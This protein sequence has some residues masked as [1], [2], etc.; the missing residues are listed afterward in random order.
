[1]SRFKALLSQQALFRRQF[2][3]LTEYQ[4]SQGK[5][6]LV[7]FDNAAT[8][9]KPQCVIDCQKNY[10]QQLNA[11]VHRGSH[12]LSSNATQLFE[13][14]RQTVQQHINAHSV[15]EIIWTKGTTEA[16]NLVAHSW[17]TANLKAG[18]EIVLSYAEHHA[19][20]VP[21]QIVA[22]KTGA[23]INVLP[24]DETGKID[25]IQLE[26]IIT[27]QTKIV[28]INHISN[29]IGKIN[30]LEKIIK[31]AKQVNALTL[32][33]GAQ[34]IAHCNIDV[35]AF[36]C[37]FYVFSAHK[38]YAPM[39]LGVLYGKEQLLEAM[40]AYQYGG[41]MIKQV[42][43]KHTTFNALP[44]KFE[45]GTPNVAAAIAFAQALVFIQENKQQIAEYESQLTQYCFAQLKK[46]TRLKFIVEGCPD[47]PIFSFVINEHH[48]HD[49][50]TS[51][52]SYG[53]AVRSGHHCTMPLM[54]YL[55]INGCIRVSLAAYNTRE[56]VDYLLQCLQKIMTSTSTNLPSLAA[57]LTSDVDLTTDNIIAIFSKCKGW[58]TRHREIMLLGKKLKR[59]TKDKR[60]EK[61]FISGCESQSWLEYQQDSEGRLLFTAD[62][63]A[64]II[65]GLLVIVLVAFQQK[66]PEQIK[67]VVIESYF[68]SLGLLQH[69]SPSRGNGVKAIVEKIR[70]IASVIPI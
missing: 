61:N 56:E 57:S 70:S 24:L 65:R 66:T 64:K 37:D 23:L 69:L 12:Q 39:G 31:R 44:F 2:P 30:P 10:Y 29:V 55:G 33:D 11:N 4:L 47:I 51:L 27:E 40:P 48:N 26:N 45:A 67:N 60:N 49:I 16:I 58:D 52:D 3:L 13:Y 46:I 5:Q 68:E 42:S 50:A 28:C 22:E 62:S 54:E 36:D 15:K 8:S 34:A 63:D 35:Q 25:D 7:Y 9:Q 53:I 32:I 20:I 19:N 17:G 21:W 43:F 59:L 38:V 1:M 6:P 18:D 41:E 14:A